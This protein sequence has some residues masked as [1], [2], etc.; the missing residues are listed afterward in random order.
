MTLA[1]NE[2]LVRPYREDHAVP[3]EEMAAMRKRLNGLGFGWGSLTM[4]G[5][6]LQLMRRGGG[7][8]GTYDTFEEML[9]AAE[10]LA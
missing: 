7:C 3:R 8:A 1:G 5:A 9:E 2:V 6:Q 4:P 10:A